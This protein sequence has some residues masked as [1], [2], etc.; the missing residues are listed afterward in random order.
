M[1]PGN[2]ATVLVSAIVVP[3]DKSTLKILLKLLQQIANTVVG[4]L[5]P[6]Y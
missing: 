2:V 1:K 3:T 5:C 4:K 6:S